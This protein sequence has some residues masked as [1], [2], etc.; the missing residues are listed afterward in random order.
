MLTSHDTPWQASNKGVLR[1]TI[2]TLH[3]VSN[4]S[5]FCNVGIL[6]FTQPRYASSLLG[7]KFH[8]EPWNYGFGPP[9]GGRVSA[10]ARGQ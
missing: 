10:S 6:I 7:G 9:W 3:H 1:C 2:T 8:G 5:H 4:G